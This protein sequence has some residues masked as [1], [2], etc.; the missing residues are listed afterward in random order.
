MEIYI[1]KKI[2]ELAQDFLKSPRVMEKNDGLLLTYDYEMD[3]G[4]YSEKSIYFEN[5]KGYRH[6]S[7]S[8]IKVDMIKAYNAIG[9]VVDSEWLSNE[10]RSQSFKH[11]IIYFDEYGAYEII[12]KEFQC[13]E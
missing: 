7:E 8:N 12:A 11:Y 10:L 3:T 1:L 5:M 9:E 2:N 4:E 13:S 6:V